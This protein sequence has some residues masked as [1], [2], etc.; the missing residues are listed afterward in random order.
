[1]ALRREGRSCREIALAVG[2]SE[3]GIRLKLLRVGGPSRVYRPASNAKDFPREEAA[4]LYVEGFSL[5]ALADR[6]GIERRTLAAALARAGVRLRGRSEAMFVR[7]ARTPEQ[8]RKR[9]AS[10]AHDAVRG[11]PKSH[12]HRCR[13][14]ATK[15]RR[16]GVGEEQLA[17]LL[18]ERGIDFTEQHPVEQY[19]LDF[20]VGHVAVE[21]RAG[22][23]NPL[24]NPK[25]RARFEYLAG[26]GWTVFYV[27]VA[28]EHALAVNAEHVIADLDMLRSLPPG[29]GQHRMVRC[30]FQ[31][32]PFRRD[33]A[34]K[35]L[36]GNRTTERPAYTVRD[37]N[38]FV[39]G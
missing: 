7:M 17:R 30:H 32:E 10:A 18:R 28:S 1:M 11:K 39:R 15:T 13:L 14:A 29:S 31:S 21:L 5:K 37:P 3:D 38:V 2:A 6:Y 8:E 22:G 36:P 33:E 27:L 35:F 34:N 20:A 26:R 4:R 19:N 16:I 23:G 12:A 25:Q 9:L 24:T